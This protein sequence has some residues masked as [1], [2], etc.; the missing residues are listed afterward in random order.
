MLSKLIRGIRFKGRPGAFKVL[1]VGSIPASLEKGDIIG[2]G[3]RRGMY[4]E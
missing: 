4:G 3:V 2:M 1:S